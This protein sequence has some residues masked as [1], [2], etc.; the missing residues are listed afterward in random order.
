MPEKA[1]PQVFIKKVTPDTILQD[2]AELMEMANYQRYFSNQEKVM[3][4]LNLSWSKYYPACSSPPW[5]VEG[6]LKKLQVDGFPSRNV[7]TCEN[8]T[9]VTNIAKGLKGNKWEPI[10]TKYNNYFVKISSFDSQL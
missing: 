4:K 10:I 5:Q 7:Y 6:V 1:R 3:V 8:R 9:V 2:Y